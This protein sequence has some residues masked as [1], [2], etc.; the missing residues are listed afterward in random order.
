MTSTRVRLGAFPAEGGTHF[1]LFSSV[2][3]HAGVR[4]FDAGGT[5]LRTEPLERSD[6]GLFERLVPGVG[7]SALYKFVLDGEEV[8][9]PY[10]RFLPFGVLG[11]ARVERP[12]RPQGRLLPHR[13]IPRTIYELHV[14][15]FTKEGTYRAAARHVPELAELGVTA[16][17]LM[18]IA[19]FSGERGWGYDGVAHFAPFAPYGEPDE[20][21]EFV[22]V[23]HEHG[24]GMILDVVYNHFGPAGNWLPRYAPEYFTEAHHT[25]WGPAL[26]FRNPWMRRYVLDN[27]RYWFEEFGFDGLRLDATHAIRDESEEPILKALSRLANVLDPP[28]YLI[29]EDERNEPALVL[30]HDL[31]AI[32]ADDFHHAVRVN[33]TGEQDGYYAA[34]SP[35]VESIAETIARGWFFDGRVYPPTGRPRGGPTADLEYPHF[36]YA[37]QNHDQVGNRAFGTRLNHEVSLDAYCAASM[38]LLFL[39]M[40]ALLFMG[41][42][43]AASS[44]FLYFTDHDAELGAL[45]SQGRREEFKRFAAFA[46][47]CARER[48]PDPQALSTFEQSR[49]EWSERTEPEHARVLELYRRLLHLRNNDPV[50]SVAAARS[51]LE[52]TAR[53]SAL[54]VRR[55][56][57]AGE[58]L[59]IAN[60]GEEP[61]SVEALSP[62]T[63]L[64]ESAAPDATALG[65]YGAAIWAGNALPLRL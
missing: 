14:G 45:V 25:P 55:R 54:I 65:R 53:G 13:G 20:L 4:L 16:L 42:E 1:S 8:G 59:L 40:T 60:F 24:L 56:G 64:V 51:E 52:A 30:H 9:D 39:P 44:P 31:D 15:T 35:S 58:R 48:I 11:P 26:D 27:A 6:A 43:W 29:A 17:E 7:P 63:R 47:P 28:R 32:W 33:L 46:D 37:I 21:R 57:K 36:V 10:A 34:Y 22:A 19:A 50:L 18:P 5:V 41:Q 38:V 23:A 12:G 3:E 62:H 61:V 49:L 2:T